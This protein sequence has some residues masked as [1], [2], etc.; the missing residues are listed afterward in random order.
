MYHFEKAFA[1]WQAIFVL[2][3]NMRALTGGALLLCI[4]ITTRVLVMM[5]V[6][7]S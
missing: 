4:I 7:I 5:V 1:K 2:A 6:M 3:C